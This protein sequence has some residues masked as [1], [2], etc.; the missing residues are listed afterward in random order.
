M[1]R[2]FEMREPDVSCLAVSVNSLRLSST[3]G[4]WSVIPCRALDRDHRSDSWAAVELSVIP[5]RVPATRASPLR[6]YE[7]FRFVEQAADAS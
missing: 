1:Q 7:Y 4:Q 6:S 3:T 5:R 2:L